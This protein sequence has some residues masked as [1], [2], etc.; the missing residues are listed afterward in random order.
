M[1]DKQLVK[2][3]M[4]M[5]HLVKI[6]IN[7]I[8]HYYNPINIIIKNSNQLFIFKILIFLQHF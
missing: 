2:T 6:M 3:M 1:N 4:D 5:I 8:I 7:I